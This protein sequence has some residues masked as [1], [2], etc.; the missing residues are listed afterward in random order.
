MSDTVKITW[1]Q[2]YEDAV[3]GG[4]F[5]LD[6]KTRVVFD[7]FPAAVLRSLISPERTN[8]VSNENP[9]KSLDL[10]V[11]EDMGQSEASL[12][13]KW[14]GPQINEV[15]DRTINPVLFN[16]SGG[17]V[18]V[19]RDQDGTRNLQQPKRT[20]AQSSRIKLRAVPR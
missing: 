17:R 19:G 8:A 10:L 13:L 6:G 12:S 16:M 2:D 4:Y 15:I 3:Y 5:L 20:D 18:I 11:L 14:P 9:R 7:R 1:H